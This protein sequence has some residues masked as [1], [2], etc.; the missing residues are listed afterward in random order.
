M[1]KESERTTSP[2]P[3]NRKYQYLAQYGWGMK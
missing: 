3:E 1:N 2:S